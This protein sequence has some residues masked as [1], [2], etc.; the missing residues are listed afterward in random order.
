MYKLNSSKTAQAYCDEFCL[1]T[2]NTI[3]DWLNQAKT[4]IG[5]EDA[6]WLATAFFSCGRAELFLKAEQSLGK[7]EER[8]L[9]Q[10]LKKRQA[11]WPLQYASGTAS[12]F[13][14]E[15][16]VERGVLIPRPETEILVE[17]AIVVGDRMP[18]VGRELRV[19]DLCSG[20]GIIAAAIKSERRNWDLCASDISPQA[21][22]LMRKNFRKHRLKIKTK[23]A[24][25]LEEIRLD[26]DLIIANPPYL[27]RGRD[28]VEPDVLKWE[29]ALALFPKGGTVNFMNRILKRI[30]NLKRMERLPAFLLL[31]LSPALAI[32]LEKNWSKQKI[33]KRAERFADLT[34]RKRFLLVEF[35]H[36]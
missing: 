10:W 19:L 28:K 25:L 3:Q 13:G 5:T 29:P 20:S 12:F 15:F 34:G 23:R 33:I 2:K 9:N 32:R 8:K 17:K 4:K 14:K 26:F 27:E 30:Q 6:L 11:G 18:V 35:Q 21:L 31:E 36:G 16:Y 7:A 1:K 22:K 24:D